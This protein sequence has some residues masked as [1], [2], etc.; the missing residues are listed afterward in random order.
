MRNIWVVFA[1]ES[2]DN[3]RDRRS[4]F[5]A[6]IYPVIGALLLG[7]L[8]SFV[9]G[10]FRG[11]SDSALFL[12]VA[13][14]DEAPEL[15]AHLTL[16]GV[17]IRPAPVNPQRAVRTGLA[18]A[19]LVVPDGHADEFADQRPAPLNMVVNATRLSTVIKV[20]RVV[21]I[22]R[23]F[24]RDVGQKRLRDH[25][26][27]PDVAS[28][29]EIRSINVGRSRNLAGFFLNMLPPFIIFTIFVGGVYLA[30]DT[31]SGER[32]RGSLEPLLANPVAR[33]QFMLGKALATFL[34]TPTAVVVQL[35]A[36]KIMFEVIAAGEYGIKLNPD[37]SAFISVALICLPLIGFAV[38]LQIIVATVSRSYKETQTYLGLL[39]LL[40]S[41]PGM[42]LVFVPIK[43]QIWMMMIPTFG[44]I[45]LI[46][47][48]MRQEPPIW[49]HIAVSVTATSLVTAI[50]LYG[51]AYLYNRDRM[52]FG[53]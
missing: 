44:Q 12:H 7:L 31:T 50:L 51:A 23:N 24:S 20:S 34:F 2:I 8:V 33:W 49:M 42:I 9:G 15:M 43:A 17:A 37:I 11:Q 46:G 22:L 25:G 29:L 41:L 38:A 27:N 18:D 52:I 28:P 53:G 26:I 36:F 35:L 30:I 5:L 19:V 6:L 45:L 21:E 10:M 39:P 47:R 13:G 3:L 4:L 48:L 16:E 14:A 1:K 40:P 32:E